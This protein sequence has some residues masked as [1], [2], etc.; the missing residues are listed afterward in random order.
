VP[1]FKDERKNR[2]KKNKGGRPTKYN[3]E[4]QAKADEYLE[5]WKQHLLS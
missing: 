4:I 2:M 5:K 3:E 1:S